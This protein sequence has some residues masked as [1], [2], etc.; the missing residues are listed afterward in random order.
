[1]D[2]K[3]IIL[4]L[5]S[6]LFFSIDARNSINIAPVRQKMIVMKEAIK[7][8]PQHV[9]NVGHLIAQA[10]TKVRR[11][12]H[13]I[14]VVKGV[15]AVV[16]SAKEGMSHA[17]DAL[18][19]ASKSTVEFCKTHPYALSALCVTASM[20]LLWKTRDKVK[21]SVAHIWNKLPFVN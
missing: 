4:S 19:R 20:P 11:L 6:L 8:V 13:T 3:I 12:R 1:M 5:F 7:K 2:R 18:L 16:K 14:R 21:S 10:P 9:K 15:R 17:Q